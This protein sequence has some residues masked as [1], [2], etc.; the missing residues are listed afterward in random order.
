MNVN[1]SGYSEFHD[2]RSEMEDSIIL[3]DD[4]NL[5]AVFDGHGRCET[6]KVGSI[7]MSKMFENEIQTKQ[8]KFDSPTEIFLEIFQK[9]EDA[10]KQKKLK[11]GSTLCLAY[12]ATNESEKNKKKVVTAHLGDARALIVLDDGKAR[13]ITKDHKPTSRS[14][15]ERIHNMNGRLSKDNRVD[16]VLAVSRSIGDFEVYG[17]GREPEVGEFEIGEKDKFLVIGCDGVFDVLSNEDVARIAVG[18]KSTKEA[19]FL[20][21]NAAFASKSADNI[22]VIVVDLTN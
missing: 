7:E 4:L 5:Y 15:F 12:I 13:E 8:L 18:C 2:L 1:K 21:R 3:R 11:D 16:G 20:I 17:V 14:E 19:A 10:I 6:A 22:S 9:V